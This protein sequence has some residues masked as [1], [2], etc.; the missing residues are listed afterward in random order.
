MSGR[1]FED[2]I[3]WRSGFLDLR[4]QKGARLTKMKIHD[5]PY[6][7]ILP[8]KLDG[9]LVAGRSISATHTAA[10]AGVAAALSAKSGRQPRDLKV[11]DLQTR[12]QSDGVS[13]DVTDRDQRDLRG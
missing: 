6:R 9:L 1:S 5:V 10:A 3:A 12:L 11:R 7:A 2:V 13:F 4:G 8:A